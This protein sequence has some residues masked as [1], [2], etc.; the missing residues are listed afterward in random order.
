M[1]RVVVPAGQAGSRAYRYCGDQLLRAHRY[2]DPNHVMS[3]FASR[4]AGLSA[5]VAAPRGHRFAAAWV[6]TPRRTA[7]IAGF[8]GNSVGAAPNDGRMGTCWCEK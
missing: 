7:P 4:A 5:A 2:I 6:W 1:R 8:G 3:H